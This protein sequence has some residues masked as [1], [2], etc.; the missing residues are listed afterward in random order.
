MLRW[1]TAVLVALAVLPLACEE[2]PKPSPA[3]PKAGTEK[4]RAPHWLKAVQADGKPDLPSPTRDTFVRLS[5]TPS[6]ED[7]DCT[8]G[9]CP[10]ETTYLR[11]REH[12]GEVLPRSTSRT[13]TSRIESR[14][15]DFDEGLVR[16]LAKERFQYQ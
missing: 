11:L 3:S 12:E 14:V 9:T 15:P 10:P 13:L 7:K 8:G 5:F 1:S 6:S 2:R 16:H 4:N